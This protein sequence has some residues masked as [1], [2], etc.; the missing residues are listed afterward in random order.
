LFRAP[1]DDRFLNAVPK[2]RCK[3]ISRATHACRYVPTLRPYETYVSGVSDKF[4]KDRDHVR[5][6]QFVG[7]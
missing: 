6:P 4:L 5:V 7:K 1:I 3:K 2:C